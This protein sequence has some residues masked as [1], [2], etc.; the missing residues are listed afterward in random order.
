MRAAPVDL[1]LQELLHCEGE[2]PAPSYHRQYRHSRGNPDHGFL[3]GAA[4]I[5]L[6]VHGALTSVE[7]AWDRA[8]L[9]SEPPRAA[10]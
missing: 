8:L 5:G 4:S 6:V 10:P 9:A 1:G 7:P 2:D 3:T